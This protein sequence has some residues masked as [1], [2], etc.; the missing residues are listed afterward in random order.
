MSKASVPLRAKQLEL[1]NIKPLDGVRAIAILLVLFW[2]YVCNGISGHSLFRH[3]TFW[4]WSGVDLFFVLSGFLIGRILINTKGNK[5]YFKIFYT[6]RIFR[7]FPA[8]YLILLLLAIFLWRGSASNFEWLA[9]APYPFYSYLFYIQ[10]FWMTHTTDFGPNWLASTWSLA[11]EEQFYLILPLLIFLVDLKNLPRLLIAGILLAPVFRAFTYPGL[12]CY[13]LLPARMDSLLIGVLIAYYH[14]IG[15][16]KKQLENK[17]TTLFISLAVSFIVLLICGRFLDYPGCGHPLLHTV[18][19]VFYGLLLTLVLVS[20]K[21]T[22]FIRF[23]SNPVLSFIARI[24]YMIYL[25]HQLF[26]GLLHQLILHTPTPEM[27]DLSGVLVT[28]LSL[29]VTILFSAISY[30]YFEKLLLNFGRK[31]KGEKIKRLPLIIGGAIVFYASVL[32]LVPIKWKYNNSFYESKKLLNT[33]MSLQNAGKIE[34]A[35]AAY[36]NAVEL[37]SKNSA[38]ANY[39]GLIYLNTKQYDSAIQYFTMSYA[40]DTTNYDILMNITV[41]YSAQKKYEEA[42]YYGNLLLKKDPA[43][44]NAKINLS[45]AYCEDGSALFGNNELEK[46]LA[47]F[48][49]AMVLDSTYA[50]ATGNIGIVYGKMGNIDLAKAYYIKALAKDPSNQIFS[51]NLQ[52][53]NGNANDFELSIHRDSLQLKNNPADKNTLA[54]MANLYVNLGMKYINRREFEKALEEFVF[55]EKADSTSPNPIGNMGVVY[56]DKGNYKKAK[57]LFERALLRD[58]K[59]EVFLQDLQAANSR[60]GK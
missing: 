1:T 6:R 9:K 35:K 13:V 23:L 37:D 27:K 39:L 22:F 8:Y 21:N 12:G 25:T 42:I 3:L 57:A 33:G 26:N 49:Q 36:K 51:R 5:N 10:N 28:L 50:I 43:N 7:I 30:Y 29:I 40:A 58:P 20:G 48:Q 44:K 14:L 55:A 54:D 60:I 34:N 2:H 59:N 31:Y 18:L 15:A 24:S 56:F 16:L 41:S 32:F 38:A 4:T 19:M 47:A 52:S 46:S 45:R 53:L 17:E 11:V